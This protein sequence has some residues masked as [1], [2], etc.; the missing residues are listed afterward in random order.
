MEGNYL[1]KNK[2][3][4]VYMMCA[5]RS[6]ASCEVIAKYSKQN[7]FI[8]Q[9]VLDNWAQFLHKQKSQPP[10]YRFYHE[11][12]SDFLHRRD[13]VQAAGVNLPDI[14]AEVADNM[15]EGLLL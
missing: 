5:L 15:T 4:I 14:S 3:K 1:R 12:F 7:Q 10:L 2:I 8:V 11:S 9:E 6:A 13:I